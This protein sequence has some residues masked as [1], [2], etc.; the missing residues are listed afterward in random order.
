YAYPNTVLTGNVFDQL[1]RLTQTCSATS[2]PACSAGTK[3]ASYAYTMGNSGNRTNVVE[4]N[5]RN[6]AYGYDNDYRLTSEVITADPGGN[7]GTENYT[8]DV[9]GNRFSLSSTIP[10]VPGSINYS[11]DANDRLT[12]DTYDANGNTTSSASIVNQYDFENR[13]TVHGGVMLVYDVDGNRVS[14]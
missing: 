14:E 1:N 11:Y 9:V 4:L 13:M 6:V 8:Y 3:L 5:N 12:T 10:S 7:N 2:S